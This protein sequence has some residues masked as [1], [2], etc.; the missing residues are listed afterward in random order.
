M[1]SNRHA[2][3]NIFVLIHDRIARK[4]IAKLDFEVHLE[5]ASQF[6]TFENQLPY[7]KYKLLA[8][9]ALIDH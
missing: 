5:L 2:S 8:L 1:S 4:H 7:S 6:A 3:I 9:Y